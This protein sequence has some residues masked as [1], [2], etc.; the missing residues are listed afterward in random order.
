MWYY[1]VLKLKH[2]HSTVSTVERNVMSL[3][4]IEFTHVL[5]AAADLLSDDGENPEYDR[6][7]TELTCDLLSVSTDSKDAV[8]NF[9]CAL[10][11]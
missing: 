7:I 4:P 6:A 1:S 9:L 10:K 5:R 8:Y 2:A 11:G 3:L